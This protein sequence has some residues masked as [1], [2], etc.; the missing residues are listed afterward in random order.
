MHEEEEEEEEK[1]AL[2]TVAR[3]TTTTKKT[4]LEY[5]LE[6]IK[7]KPHE[8]SPYVREFVE[9]KV[10]AEMRKN[11][12]FHS[13]LR[14]KSLVKE[15]EEATACLR[16]IERVMKKRRE[17]EDDGE[18]ITF[19]DLCS[20]KGFLSIVLS[21]K[22]PKAR[23]E[24]IDLDETANMEHV[25]AMEN[26][27]FHCLD[28]TS[29]ECEKIVEEAGKVSKFVVICG[30]HLCGDLSRV[31]IR[32]WN[33]ARQRMNGECAIVLSPCCLPQRRRHDA[34]GFHVKD[35]ARLL[36]V[37]NYRLWCIFL[38]LEMRRCLMEDGDGDPGRGGVHMVQD[39]FMTGN[40]IKNT[41]LTCCCAKC[42]PSLAAT[43]NGG[44]KRGI[45]ASI[46]QASRWKIAKT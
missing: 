35:Q 24:M 5:T 18:G 1:N 20:G 33:E 25:A 15:I 11:E 28:V 9:S 38:S 22:Y 21:F 6:N 40:D 2:R 27:N 7:S 36:K 42:P 43:T 29:R 44:K 19:V 4:K 10:C 13:W 26:V 39:E 16:Q 45:S 32:L 34:F 30:V 41:F 46:L 31:A 8:Y 37:D 23:V 3:K 12:K 14:K 17:R